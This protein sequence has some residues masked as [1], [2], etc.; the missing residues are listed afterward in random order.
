MACCCGGGVP[1]DCNDCCSYG[2]AAE[3]VLISKKCPQTYIRFD[4]VFSG[5]SIQVVSDNFFGPKQK[6]YTVSA[7]ATNVSF[8]LLDNVP[9]RTDFALNISCA[10]TSNRNFQL[11][12]VTSSSPAFV[13]GSA[14]S[15]LRPTIRRAAGCS[16]ELL[17]NYGGL[18]LTT[19]TQHDDG[20]ILRTTQGVGTV[21]S[22][23]SSAISGI[24]CLTDLVGQV[25][26]GDLCSSIASSSEV[27]GS[28]GL[29]T[30]GRTTVT[31]Q[32]NPTVSYTVG[33]VGVLPLP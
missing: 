13:N 18:A 10:H 9:G 16:Y 12:A 19:Q 7:P 33:S 1:T 29:G 31:L 26:S 23:L 27:A 8:Y 5:F 14:E 3:S 24:A 32:S 30:T 11:S 17:Y 20:L 4:V 2:C 28:S 6:T 22:G 21:N 15:F 25:F